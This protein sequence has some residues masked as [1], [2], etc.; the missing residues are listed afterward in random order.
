M[1]SFYLNISDVYLLN[2]T[3]SNMLDSYYFNL[4]F[5]ESQFYEA[6]STDVFQALETLIMY[7]LSL[8]E[9]VTPVSAY[10]E[11]VDNGNNL[12]FLTR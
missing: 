5:S 8:F 9:I 1:Q 2:F 7:P 11:E 3:T 4:T 6:I 10:E 12:R